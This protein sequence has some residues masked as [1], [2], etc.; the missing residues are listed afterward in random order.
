MAEPWFP[1]GV[2]DFPRR[3]IGGPLRSILEAQLGRDGRPAPL[4]GLAMG[5]RWEDDILKLSWTLLGFPLK[6]LP[7]CRP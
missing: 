6:I 5:S 4:Q 2:K 3:N 7:R 1:T